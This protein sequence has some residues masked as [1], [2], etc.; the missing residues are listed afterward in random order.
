MIELEIEFSKK[1]CD[2]ILFFE[3]ICFVNF[4]IEVVM[5]IICVVCVY[6]KRNKIIKFVGFYYG[7]FDLVLVVVGS[8]LF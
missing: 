2:V 3:K 4:G 7:Y 8:G 6:I 5:I 1:L